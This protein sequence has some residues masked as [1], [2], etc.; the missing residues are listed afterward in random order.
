MSNYNDYTLPPCKTIVMYTWFLPC[1]SCKEKITRALQP[2]IRTGHQVILAYTKK[3]IR[4]DLIIRDLNRVGIC[5]EEVPYTKV[6]APASGPNQV[7]LRY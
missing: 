2:Y 6:L 1:V 5:V 7:D 3:T 4:S